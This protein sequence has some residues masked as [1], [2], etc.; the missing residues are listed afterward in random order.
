MKIG[1]VTVHHAHNYGAMLQAYALQQELVELGYETELIDYDEIKSKI[2]VKFNMK[3]SKGFISGIFYN[4]K[5][6]L[7]YK[8]MKTAFN[9]FEDFYNNYYYKSKKFINYDDIDVSYLDMLL[10]GS[11][12][13]WSFKQGGNR[14]FFQLDFDKKIMKASYAASMGGFF[15]L[16][17]EQR[18]D[19]SSSLQA[20]KS[21]SVR[22]RETGEYIKKLIGDIS[23][24]VS[25]DPV[26]LLD[27]ERWMNLSNDSFQYE[28]PDK[29]ILCYELIKGEGTEECIEKLKKKYDLPVVVLHA[30]IYS[31]IKG[32]INIY[33]AGP[34]EMIYLINH[35][36]GVVTS[37]F[38][39]TV[40]SIVFDKPFYS[41]LTKHGP[42]RISEMLNNMRLSDRIFNLGSDVNLDCDFDY[43][44]KILEIEKEQSINYLRKLGEA[45]KCA[46]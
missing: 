12:Q 3:S 44:R 16:T 18:K 27:R 45:E 25:L 2:F 29:Y 42:G 4:L 40:F 36:E 17:D 8:D 9:R 15:N 35:S 24:E 30:N 1:T 41:I 46:E 5:T 43:S 7:H 32:D 22:E 6:I 34:L 19:F 39:G 28:L 10:V 11:D 26:F 23:Y 37:S 20:F 13:V 33:D 38:H 31:A 14:P 21:F